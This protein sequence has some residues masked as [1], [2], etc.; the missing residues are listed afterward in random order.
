M[1]ASSLPG[2]RADFDPTPMRARTDR[3]RGR[4]D[5]ARDWSIVIPIWSSAETAPT[6]SSCGCRAPATKRSRVRAAASSRPWRRRAPPARLNSSPA[7]LPRLD[8]LI[9]EGVT[10]VEIKSGYGLDDGRP[11]CGSLSAAR[12]VGRDRPVSDP[13]DRSSA[14]TRCRPKP[15]ATR[16]DYI[17]LVCREMLPA[18]AQAGLADAVDAFMRRHRVL[19]EQTPRGC[20][21]RRRR[22]DCRSSCTPDQLSNLGGAALRRQFSARCPPIIW[23]TPDEAGVAAMAR[24]R[25]CRRAAARRVLFHSRDDEAAGR[26]CSAPTA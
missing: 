2:S 22:S 10:T 8:A 25:H 24:G 1:A 20:S 5:H 23:S 13:H 26:G 4:V 16:I 14:R 7:R 6:S 11:R 17:D 15:M 18:V 3:L 19:A 9:G 12:S 21:R